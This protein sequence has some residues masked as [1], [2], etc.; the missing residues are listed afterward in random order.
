MKNVK[1]KKTDGYSIDEFKDSIITK[2]LLERYDVELSD[3][4][5]YVFAE[6]TDGLTDNYIKYPNAVRIQYTGENLCPDFNAFDYAFGFED[7][8]F[9]DRYYRY[10]LCVMREDSW[11]LME[12]KHL[13]TEEKIK[14]RTEFCSFVVSKPTGLASSMREDMF[15]K[16]CEYKKVNSG[17]RYLNNI[18]QPEGVKD[19]L[20][21]QQKHKFAICAENVSHRGYC[22]E[23]LVEAFA[24]GCIPI[25]WGDPIAKEIFN[26]ESYIDCTEMKSLDE[27]IEAVKKIDEDDELYMKM[28]RTSAL[29]NPDFKSDIDEGFR[30]FLYNIFEQDFENAFRRDRIGYGYLYCNKLM[31]SANNNLEMSQKDVLLHIKLK[32]KLKKVL[33]KK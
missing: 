27:M 16:L 20:E 22:T 7:L 8:S 24:A 28:I 26:P 10:P 5:D 9:G 12:R 32:N 6:V 1:I 11:K 33:G 15:H 14:Q 3:E 17:G 18:G 19:K 21:F 13:Q 30:N 25:Y 4:P 29:I 23:K 2:I 31:H